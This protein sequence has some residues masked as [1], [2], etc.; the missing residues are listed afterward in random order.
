MEYT[1]EITIE[2]PRSL[3]VE[4][5]DDPENMK[6]WQEGLLEF[7]H[8]SGDPGQPGA[9]SRLLFERSGRKIEM[10]ETVV[11]RDL[12]HEFHGK[13]TTEGVEN[14][15]KNYFIAEGPNKTRWVTENRFEFSGMMRIVSFFMRGAFPKQTQQFM[16]DFKEFAES[17]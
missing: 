4:L 11:K 12:P 15:V 6:H 10:I 3:V 17:H 1:N 13:Y 7:E 2:R 9:S 5:F 14:W 8:V 16:Q